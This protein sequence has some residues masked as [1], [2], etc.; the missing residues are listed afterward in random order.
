MQTI[1]I[2]NVERF[3]VERARSSSSLPLISDDKIARTE[4]RI[5]M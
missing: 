3:R 5:A 1:A 2:S 4:R